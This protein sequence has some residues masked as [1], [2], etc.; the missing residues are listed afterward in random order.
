MTCKRTKKRAKLSSF[1]QNKHFATKVFSYDYAQMK[2]ELR[3][4]NSKSDFMTEKF[5]MKTIQCDNR[6]SE[7]TKYFDSS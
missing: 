1:K 5:P 3:R 6:I 7:N 4:K 2:C